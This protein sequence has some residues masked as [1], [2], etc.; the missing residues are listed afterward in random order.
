MIV[1]GCDV[2]TSTT[3]AVVMRDDKIF[4]DI[5][6]TA[7]PDQ[8]AKEVTERSLLKAHLVWEDI[9]YFISTGWGRKRVPHANTN[10]SEIVCHGK[11]AQWLI[12]SVR[13]VIDGG[14]EG[15]R[16][17]TVDEKGKVVEYI[18]NPKC[19][20]GAGKF[21]EVMAKA[22]GLNLEDLGPLAQR[23]KNRV[24][25]TSQCS[26]FAESEVIAY[27]NEGKD[28]ADV[29]DGINYSIAGRLASLVK[30]ISIE[31]DVTVTGGIA[32]NIRLLKHLEELLGISVKMVPADPQIVGAIGA[33]LLAKEKML[34]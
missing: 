19:S 32:K 15:T 21:L 30:G 1:A 33:A 8:T 6:T 26:V 25:I 3:K 23:S 11:G 31:E 16:V 28:L 12:P 27:I 34:K 18:T 10:L 17:I 2:G 5:A 29:V 20:A 4:F 24:A 22:L 14:S 9:E 7:K 13:T